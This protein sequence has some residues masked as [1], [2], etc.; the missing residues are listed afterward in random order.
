MG[1]FQVF[2]LPARLFCM[3]PSLGFYGVMAFTMALLA[4]SSRLL[5]VSPTNGPPSPPTTLD[6]PSVLGITSHVDEDKGFIMTPFRFR[7][8]S[9]WNPGSTR[10][11]AE[12]TVD[13]LGSPQQIAIYEQT[14]RLM[15]GHV[16]AVPFLGR[17]T[18]CLIGDWGPSSNITR[19]FRMEGSKQVIITNVLPSGP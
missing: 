11:V 10:K 15:T 6:G 3:R 14:G 5:P 8:E 1:S 4:D 17:I 2:S 7:S 13:L 19:R 9:R 16:A 12:Y 18:E